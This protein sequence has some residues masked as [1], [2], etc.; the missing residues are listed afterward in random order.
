MT[1]LEAL[2]TLWLSKTAITDLV[3]TRIHW[4]AHRPQGQPLRDGPAITYWKITGEDQLY[5]GG[6]STLETCRVR[7]RC[8][9]AAPD[10]AAAV[11]NALRDETQRYSGTI[12]ESVTVVQATFADD[13]EDYLEPVDRSDGGAYLAEI[14]LHVWWRPPVP[15]PA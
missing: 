13:A 15:S 3:S 4:G 5:Q 6:T 10:T 11:R 12:A 2:A 9:A 7:V 8:W 14:D 1:L